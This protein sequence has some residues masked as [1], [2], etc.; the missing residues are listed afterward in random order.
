MMLIPILCASIFV[1]RSVN[2]DLETAAS[3]LRG[4]TFTERQIDLMVQV[5]K[6]RGMVNLKLAGENVDPALE[7]YAH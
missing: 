5:Q 4:L 6:H 3:E 1:L 2:I 7:K